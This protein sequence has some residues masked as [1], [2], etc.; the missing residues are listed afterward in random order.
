MITLGFDGSSIETGGCSWGKKRVGGT[1]GLLNLAGWQK[2][3]PNSICLSNPL[4]VSPLLEGKVRPLPPIFRP[5]PPSSGDQTLI[6]LDFISLYLFFPPLYL[7]SSRILPSLLLHPFLLQ[8]PPTFQFRG[9][10]FLA[11][12]NERPRDTS[13]IVRPDRWRIS[14]WP[15]RPVPELVISRERLSPLKWNWPFRSSTHPLFLIHL[16]RENESLSDHF[17]LM[18]C[19]YVFA[20]VYVWS[21][22]WKSSRC[23]RTLS[24]LRIDGVCIFWIVDYLFFL[25]RA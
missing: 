15:V 22:C 8:L 7:P 24:R 11:P 18:V 3:L 1:Y 21:L 9:D 14:L 4:S 25:D 13:A 17:E 23:L 12:R 16:A 19:V 10:T 5:R 20:C 6:G 2:L